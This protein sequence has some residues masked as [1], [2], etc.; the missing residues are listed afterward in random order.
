MEI[1]N[2]YEADKR[3]NFKLSSEYVRL[4]NNFNNKKMQSSFNFGKRRSRK[5]RSR[6]RRSHKKLKKNNSNN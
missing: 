2:L 6:K 5:R 4:I 3:G 1:L